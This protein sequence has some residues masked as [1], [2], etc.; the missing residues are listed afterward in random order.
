MA[1]VWR[2]TFT[3]CYSRHFSL[4]NIATIHD[5]RCKWL[6]RFLWLLQFF[7]I[8]SPLQF[9]VNQTSSEILDKCRQSGS[10]SQIK[11][12]RPSSQINDLLAVLSV[13]ATVVVM[14]YSTLVGQFGILLFYVLWLPRV[15]SQKKRLLR[16]LQCNILPLVYIGFCLLS[17]LWSDHP[18]VTA[19]A[20]LEAA[21]MVICTIAI[22]LSV[23]LE[24]F[25]RGS[26]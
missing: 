25:I 26:S 15:F 14:A 23:S 13:A 2:D 4:C 9:R 10:P 8:S 24:T 17:V 21:S 19:R 18:L 5:A 20:A 12:S 7:Q 6:W 16:S 11:P 1:H 3:H 22:S